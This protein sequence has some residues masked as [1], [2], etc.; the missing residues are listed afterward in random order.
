MAPSDIREC[1]VAYAWDLLNCLFGVIDAKLEAKHVD[2]V[3]YF[4]QIVPRL[5]G[6]VVNSATTRYKDMES[7]LFQDRRLVAL[8]GQ[9]T[10]TMTWQLNS[11]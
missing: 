7:H 10:E 8:A 3:K 11:E 5:L 6:L 4:D 2:S 1:S 9:T